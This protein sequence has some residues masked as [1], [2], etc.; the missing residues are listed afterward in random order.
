MWTA[1][2][3]YRLGVEYDDDGTVVMYG[4]RVQ[5]VW[6]DIASAFISFA[7]YL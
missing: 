5:Y 4:G 7:L 3:Y 6:C 1:V 2:G